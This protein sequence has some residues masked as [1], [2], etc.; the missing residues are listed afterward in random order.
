MM[1][2]NIRTVRPEDLD[3]VAG[4]ERRCFPAGEAATRTALADRI[5]TIP[6]WFLVAEVDGVLAGLVNGPATELEYIQDALFAPG[7]QNPA[8]RT[9]AILGLAVDAS[10]RKQG[11]A[12]RLLREYLRAARIG[13]MDRVVLTCKERLI[14][15]YRKF[16]FVDKGVSASVHGGVVWYDMELNL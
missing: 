16:G 14:P 7:A 1:E 10:Y 9:L 2:L 4:L 13:G 11:V 15:Y 3:A 5:Q 8:G 12:A 6:Q